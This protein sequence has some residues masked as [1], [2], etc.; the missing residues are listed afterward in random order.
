MTMDNCLQKVQVLI[1]CIYVFTWCTLPWAEMVRKYLPYNCERKWS[2]KRRLYRSTQYMRTPMV[3]P[4]LTVPD[5]TPEAHP[6]CPPHV[7]PPGPS[8]PAPEMPQQH[9]PAASYN[10]V[11]PVPIPR[12]VTDAGAPLLLSPSP[13]STQA[14]AALLLRLKL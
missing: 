6:H 14:A 8:A 12:A 5:H 7:S 2:Q 13:V 1:V 4:A 9:Q 10:S 3:P 11:H